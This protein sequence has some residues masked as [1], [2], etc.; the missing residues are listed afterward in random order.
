M[1]LGGDKKKKD[2]TNFL[3]YKSH[4]TRHGKQYFRHHISPCPA[5]ICLHKFQHKVY[6]Q[7][8]NASLFLQHTPRYTRRHFAKHVL[9]KNIP[10]EK[11]KLKEKKKVFP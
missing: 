3:R 5:T 10:S 2:Q 7:L 11:N 8:G 4:C 9:G 1:E 6:Q